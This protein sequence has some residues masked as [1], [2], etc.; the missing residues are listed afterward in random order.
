MTAPDDGAGELH[1]LLTLLGADT[2]A[3]ALDRLYE[4]QAMVPVAGVTVLYRPNR[5]ERCVV[6]T[7]GVPDTPSARAVLRQ[8]LARVLHDLAYAD[9]QVTRPAPPSPS[10]AGPGHSP[11]PPRPRSDR[12]PAG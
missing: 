6:T 9:E 10:P 1:Q 11:A 7:L 8:V 4:L 3:A 5:P 12:P 2:P